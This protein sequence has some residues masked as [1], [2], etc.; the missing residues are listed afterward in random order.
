MDK[1]ENSHLLVYQRYK[2]ED[3]NEYIVT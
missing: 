1:K 3:I 2:T